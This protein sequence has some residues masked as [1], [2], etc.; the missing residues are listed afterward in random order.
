MNELILVIC[1][2]VFVVLLS[3]NFLKYCLIEIESVSLIRWSF[4]LSPSSASTF[5]VLYD[6][7]RT[8]KSIGVKPFVSGYDTL[9]PSLANSVI[10]SGMSL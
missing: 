4:G 3:F 5:K 10:T 6:L 7:L 1:F 8:A 2:N 9:T